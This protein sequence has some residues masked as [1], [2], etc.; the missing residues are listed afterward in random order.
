MR[1]RAAVSPF[2]WQ[3]NKVILSYFTQNSVSK[4]QFG[5]SAQRPSFVIIPSVPIPASLLLRTSPGAPGL[6]LLHHDLTLGFGSL[7]TSVKKVKVSVTQSC[8]TLC[9]P[10]DC[11]AHLPVSS[12]HR[13]L[14]AKLLVWVGISS[15]RESS[16]PKD[17]IQVSSTA[18]RFLTV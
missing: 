17:R 9:D 5:T 4:I 12:V 8:L 7:I 1:T 15:P 16:Q 11:R 13:I 10:M 14:Q 18:G 2:A 3:S 6:T